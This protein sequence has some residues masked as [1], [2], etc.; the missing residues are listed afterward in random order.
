MLRWNDLKGRRRAALPAT[1]VLLALGVCWYTRDTPLT[2]GWLRVDALSAWFLTLAALGCAITFGRTEDKFRL[3]T[4][5]SVACLLLSVLTSFIPFIPAALLLASAGLAR[6]P[7]PRHWRDRTCWFI[8]GMCPM[9]GYSTLFLRGVLYYDAAN[10]SGALASAGFWFVLLGIVAALFALL[11]DGTP[12]AARAF[13]PVWLYLLVRLY[14]LGEWNPAWALAMLLVGLL[15]RR[16]NR[17]VRPIY[18]AARQ[19]LGDLTA[20]L[21]DNLNGIRVIQSFAQER[22]EAASLEQTGRERILPPDLLLAQVRVYLDLALWER[23]NLALRLAETIGDAEINAEAT[24]PSAEVAMLQ[25]RFDHAQELLQQVT[26]A[27]LSPRLQLEYYLTLG[28]AQVL[29]GMAGPAIEA[30]E[31]ANELT[32]QVVSASQLPLQLAAISDNLGWAYA[33]Q[34]DRSAALRHLKRADACWQASGNQGRRAMTLNNL[35]V[36]ATEEGLFGEARAAFIAGVEVAQ[37]TAR[38]REELYLQHSLAELE[39]MEGNAARALEIFQTAYE[40]AVRVEVASGIATAAAGALWAAALAGHTELARQW[41]AHFAPLAERAAPL[42]R[43]RANLARSLLTSTALTEPALASLIASVAGNDEAL[44]RPER[45][46]LAVLQAAAEFASHDW[47]AAEPYWKTFEQNADLPEPFVHRFVRSQLK[48]LQAAASVSEFARRLLATIDLPAQVRWYIVTLG[49]FTCLVDGAPV[50][51]SPLHRALLVRLLDAGEAG[52]TVDRLWEEVWGDSDLRMSALH[53]AIFRVRE[54]TALAMAAKAGH[55]AIQSPLSAIEYDVQLFERAI[56]NAGTAAELE[57][58]LALYHGDFLPGAALSA[59]LWI[60]RRRSLLQQQYLDGL[61]RLAHLLEDNDPRQAIQIYQQI[62]GIDGC[63]EET[64]T[65]LMRVAARQRNLALVNATYE[66]L[67]SALRLLGASPEP[68]TVALLHST[69]RGSLPA[70]QR[71]TYE[72]P[73]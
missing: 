21:A 24:I 33:T 55:C 32:P 2:Y 49:Q 8:A 45:A 39:I 1:L 5:F 25:G 50:E 36:L 7:Q 40:L 65:L 66:Q 15:L 53:K 10:A 44:T 16:Y 57:A 47:Q 73:A 63:R 14:S 69:T 56:A 28:R 3:T 13:A 51:L 9:L 19:R 70:R 35:G 34:G 43:A 23:A 67:A 62:L 54:Q 26:F 31:A 37:Q 27:A 6:A 72:H 52:L 64:A 29:G 42:L 71:A 41:A 18:R 11:R 20:R 60:D 38:Y 12:F 30:L 58:A 68:A 4:S 61:E 22:R 48:L 17:R 46:Y 59:A